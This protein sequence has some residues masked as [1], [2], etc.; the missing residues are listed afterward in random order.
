MD[1]F[2][3]LEHSFKYNMLTAIYIPTS[4][5]PKIGYLK[6]KKEF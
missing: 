2:K 4:K 3:V 5:S 6:Y 1:S